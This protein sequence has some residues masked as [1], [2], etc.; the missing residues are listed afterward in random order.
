MLRIIR[1]HSENHDFIELVKQLDAELAIRDGDDHAYYAQFNKTDNLK[2][3]I[4][5][6]E[7]LKPVGC[8]AIREYAAQVMEVKRMY[9]APGERGK[10]IASAI[11]QELEKWAAELLS[12]KCILETGKNQ[13]EAIGLYHSNKYRR[14]PNYGQYAGMENSVCFEKLIS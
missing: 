4:V 10:G 11:L 1:T 3:V 9:T 2:N 6:Y 8:G 13:P 5:A 14:I 12:V 7:D